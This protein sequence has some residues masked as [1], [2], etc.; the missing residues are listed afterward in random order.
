[1]SVSESS[2]TRG[3][4]QR[5]L[6]LGALAA[7]IVLLGA[8]ATMAYW[9]RAVDLLTARDEQAL[10]S[11][12]LDRRLERLSEDVT[13]ATIWDDAWTNTASRFDPEWVNT[14][15]GE[16]YAEYMGHDRTIAFDAADKATYAS[17]DG[18][19]RP[20]ASAASFA[21]AVR[22][23]LADVRAAEKA[24]G[25]GR[26]SGFEG[27]VT[28]ARM[29]GADGLVW[30]V[31][32]STVTPE[33]AGLRTSAAPAPVVV[34]A[35]RIDSDFLTELSKDLGIAQPHLAAPDETLDTPFVA[36][37]DGSGRPLGRLTWTP[38]APGVAVMMQAGLPFLLVVILVLALGAGL[39]HRVNRGLAA[40]AA[41]DERLAR[42]LAEL[43]AARDRAEA[44]S[45]AK[46]QFLANISH[47]IRTP[48]NG[49]LGMAQIM[50]KGELDG[51]Q[52]ERLA[53]IRES[54][55]TLLRILNDVLDLAKIE[56]GKLEITREVVDLQAVVTAA[57]EPFRAAATEKGL[58]FGLLIEPDALGHW[59]LDAMRVSQVLGNLLSNAVKFTAEGHVSARVWRSERG[60]EFAVMDTG[61]GI[62]Q[63]RLADLFGKFNQL[64]AS[65]T[66][67][68]GGTGLGL[69]ICRELVELM[70]GE[71][72]VDSR[73]GSGSWFT[74]W[75]PA[76]PADHAER[77]AA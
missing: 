38:A 55:S 68:Y 15:Y 48:L 57:V 24:L 63:D 3:R 53:I 14:N 77:T 8:V 7:L 66:R 5:T 21:R 72:E 71:L 64:D 69:A 11:R 36:L 9:A 22:A 26:L 56:A 37:K 74:F 28:R 12:T 19:V 10:V 61:P 60:L 40:L 4:L 44:A 50:A 33:N 23:L 27:N 30:L 1:M 54:G 6:I 73:P 41:N 67:Q 75:L 49:V 39:F 25:P 45:V 18:E 76:K 65:T 31:A 51:A 34:T 46:S 62:P 47:E 32:I 59:R 43:T 52:R 58:A 17:E 35:Y 42:T 2:T 29:I 13:S 70:D 20:I 16:Y